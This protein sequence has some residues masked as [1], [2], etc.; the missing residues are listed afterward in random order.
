[1]NQNATPDIET[2]RREIA[3]T[4]HEHWRVF[5][6]EGI[7][8]MVLGLAAV[9]LPNMSTVAVE[10]LIGWL[11]LTGG[12]V[13]SVSVLRSRQRPG[14]GWS[15]LTA[16]LAAIFGL[17]LIL[18]PIPG[19]MTLTMVLVAFFIV[20]GIAAI[21]LALEHRDH[22]PSWGWVLVSGLIDLL[23]AALIWGGWPSS[24]VWAIGL[25][26]GVNMFFF[27]LSLVMTAMAA[28][29]MGER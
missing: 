6:A 3:R 17:V 28:R 26:V 8:M 19:V 13:R 18:A 12:I 24:A 21:F 9:A 15:L 4:I 5:L 10:L 16:A 11:F 23:L 14:Y 7:L 20:E 27:G 22:L 1:M 2:L 25:L 29:V